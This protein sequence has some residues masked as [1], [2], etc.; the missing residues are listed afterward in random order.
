M[1]IISIQ[2]NLDGH[3][4]LIRWRLV[5]HAG[6]DGYSRMIVFIHC[7]DNN[8]AATVYHHFLEAAREFGLPSRVRSDQGKENTLVARHMLQKRGENRGS[9][10]TGSSIHN[11]RIER[12]WRDVFQSVIGMFY[13][14]FY[15]MEHHDLLNPT[16]EIHL[17]ALH[18]IFLPRIN[19]SLLNFK[20]SWNHHSIR[21]EHN[22]TPNQLFTSGALR[23]RNMGMVSLDFFD[24]VNDQ[25]G[26]DDGHLTANE[27]NTEVVIPEVNIQLTSNQMQQIESTIN[28][29]ADSQNYGIELYITTVDTL[30][31]MLNST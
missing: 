30:Q 5:T 14:L 10:I 24:T 22:S 16:N 21:T 31:R 27:D 18:H 25:Y 12:L 1:V 8:K 2:L 7:S 20:S 28:P 11:Q 13:R 6:I 9:M 26:I 23:L 15:H 4:K 17:F 3:H 19:R 29:L